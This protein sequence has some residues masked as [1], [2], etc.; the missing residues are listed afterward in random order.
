MQAAQAAQPGKLSLAWQAAANR[1]GPLEHMPIHPP[2]QPAFEDTS[3]E[4]VLAINFTNDDSVWRPVVF[5]RI[6]EAAQHVR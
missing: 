5:E 1:A 6:C 4:A 3:P 2:I